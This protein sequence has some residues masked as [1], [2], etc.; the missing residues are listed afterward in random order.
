MWQ[1][2]PVSRRAPLLSPSHSQQVYLFYRICAA[3]ALWAKNNQKEFFFE[4][5]RPFWCLQSCRST[6]FLIYI[7]NH[8]HPWVTVTEARKLEGYFSIY[9]PHPLP[10]LK[11]PLR[12]QIRLAYSAFLRWRLSLGSRVKASKS[13]YPTW[14]GVELGL[15]GKKSTESSIQL[16]WQ[17]RKLSLSW[18]SLFGER[19]RN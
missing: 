15:K 5:T 10:K 12:R 9:P 6:F 13:F 18:I 1:F 7:F 16:P 19:R 14:K 2:C 4:W 8:I 3:G 17:S 11:S